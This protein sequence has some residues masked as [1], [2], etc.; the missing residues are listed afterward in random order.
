M[1]GC[2]GCLWVTFVLTLGTAVTAAGIV[3]A[4]WLP[5]WQTRGANLAASAIMITVV[6]LAITPRRRS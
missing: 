2:L 6:L 1:R 3:A 4:R 5:G